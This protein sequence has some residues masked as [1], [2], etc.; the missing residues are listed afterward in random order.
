MVH[1]AIVLIVIGVTGSTLHKSEQLV[2][3]TPGESILFEGYELTYEGYGVDT[4]GGVPETYESHIRYEATLSAKRDGSRIRMLRPEKNY[5]WVLDSPWVTEVAI[6][7]TLIEDLYVVL[8]SLDEDGRASFELVLN[9][10]ISWLWIGGALLLA[11]AVLAA[12][13]SRRRAVEGG[14]DA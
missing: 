12:W 14:A 4:V 9:P 7:S 6:A 2:S 5:H 3:L 8:A 1:F 13:P 10:L 11:G